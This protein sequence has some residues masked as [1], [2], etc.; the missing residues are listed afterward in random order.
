[1]ANLNLLSD[2]PVEGS[3]QR[4]SMGAPGFEMVRK[5]IFKTAHALL[6]KYQKR[7]K[8]ARTG[9]KDVANYHDGK[10]HNEG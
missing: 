1:M 10:H 6:S 7:M 3:R 2:P 8:L 5:D 4:P 9:G